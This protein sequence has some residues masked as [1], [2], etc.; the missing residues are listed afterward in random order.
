M[1][2]T[3]DQATRRLRFRLLQGRF[4]LCRLPAHAALPAWAT[5]GSPFWVART[6]DELSLVCEEGLVP[7]GVTH[8]A[9]YA[10]LQLAGPFA[11]TESG[12]LAAFLAPLAAARI[13]AF[14]LSTYDTDYV[15]VAA[16]QLPAARAALRAAG[17]TE[18]EGNA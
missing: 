11:L 5:A 1:D 17:H 7:A 8:G 12:V 15:L 10:C 4:A 13:P 14:A 3:G 16:G 18:M 6:G 9:G 2:P